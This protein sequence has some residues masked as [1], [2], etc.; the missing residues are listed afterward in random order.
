MTIDQ[1]SRTQRDAPSELDRFR[2]EALIY[3]GADQFVE[4]TAQF[5]PTGSP[6]RNR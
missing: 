6:P 2:H 3:R 4:R 1:L 5:V